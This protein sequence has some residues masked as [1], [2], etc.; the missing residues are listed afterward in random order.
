MKPLYITTKE[1]LVKQLPGT[2]TLKLFHKFQNLVIETKHE[3]VITIQKA[4]LPE[5]IA[6]AMSIAAAEDVS[7][8]AMQKAFA[9]VNIPLGKT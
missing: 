4:D 5:V 1:D 7:L 6:A 3:G 2:P 8:Q 9:H